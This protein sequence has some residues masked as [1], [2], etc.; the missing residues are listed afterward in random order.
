MTKT[1]SNG[2]GPMVQRRFALGA[3]YLQVENQEEIF[4]K[5][6]KVRRVI[7]D[8]FNKIYEENDLLIFPSTT[9]APTIAE[10]KKNC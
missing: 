5:A 6:Q 3:F 2:F 10:G 1:R 4:I 9:I 8:A 7:T